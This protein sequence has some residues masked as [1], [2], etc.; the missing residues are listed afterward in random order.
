MNRTSRRSLA[1]WAADQLAA[2]Q[3]VSK[4]ARGLTAILAESK[5]TD[6]AGFLI[7]DIT[8][9]LEH[10]RILTVANVTSASPLSKQLADAMEKQLRKITGS[11]KVVVQ[12]AVDKSVVGG[13]RIETTDRVWDNTVIH[14]LSELR[15]AF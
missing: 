1:R 2:G 3:P 11:A 9:E 10:R 13:I 8:W 14:Q 5:M 6:Q 4:I 15:E 7:E 12:P